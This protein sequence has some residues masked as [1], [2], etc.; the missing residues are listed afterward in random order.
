V[1]YRTYLPGAAS[2]RADS[3]PPVR[4]N[5]VLLARLCA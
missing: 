4:D 1:T 3:A 5:R 2:P